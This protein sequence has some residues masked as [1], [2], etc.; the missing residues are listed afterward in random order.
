MLLTASASLRN[1]R[2]EKEVSSKEEGSR[3][4]AE[5]GSMERN[6]LGMI[7]LA[8]HMAVAVL[9]GLQDDSSHSVPCQ[10]KITV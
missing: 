8:W 3:A 10:N 4:A 9:L 1:Q 6:V 7:R 5:S 2:K